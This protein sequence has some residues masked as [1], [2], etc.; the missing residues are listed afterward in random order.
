MKSIFIIITIIV[1]IN[2]CNNIINFINAKKAYKNKKRKSGYDKSNMYILLPVYKEESIADIMVDR[3][4]KISKETNVKTIIIATVKEKDNKTYNIL[5]EKIKKEKLDKYIKLIKCDIKEGTMATQLNYAIDYIDTF[6]KSDY[7]V[8]IHNADGLISKEHIEFVRNNV[9]LETCVQSYSYFEN[10]SNVLLN[11]PVSWQNRWSYIYEAG[12][13][14]SKFYKT[15]LFRNMNYVIGH[16]LY[17]KSSVLK[18]VGYFPEDTI[19]EDAFL[20]LLLN[21]KNYKIIP[22]PYFEKADFAPSL[23]IYIKQQSVWF[24]GPKMAFNYLYRIIKNKPNRRYDRMLY[25]NNL[26]NF[27]NLFIFSFK[28]F[29]MAIYWI[30][31]V[32]ILFVLYGYVSYKLFGVFGLVYVYLINYLNLVGFNYLSFREIKKE[33][34]DNIKFPFLQFPIIF[35]FIHSFGPILNVI[36]S[37]RGRNSIKNKYKTER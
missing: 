28:L 23:K 17:L 35:Y 10:N 36:N 6:D 24:N 32:Y 26:L 21:Y 31:A 29:L 34:K 2:Y 9:N 4:Y 30:S 18:S 16:G 20:G 12:R 37:I 1:I 19:N 27:I 22:L 11:G 13:C 25:K 14:Y 15:S 7:I 5:E 8:G 33:T 3:F